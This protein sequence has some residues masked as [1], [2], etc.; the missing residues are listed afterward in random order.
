ML[1]ELIREAAGGE[2]VY[3]DDTTVKILEL[4]SAPA[5][6]EA[7]AES[8]AAGSDSKG[9]TRTGLFTSGV[10]ATRGGQRIALFFSGPQHAGENLQDVL[11]RRA[12]DLPPPIQM[13]DALSRNLPKDLHTIVANCLAH[14]RRQ[15][16]DVHERFPSECGYVLEA[17]EVVYRHDALARQRGLDERSARGLIVEGMA[18]AWLTRAFGDAQLVESLDLE[19]LL[20]QTVARHLADEIQALPEKP[21]G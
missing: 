13:C 19:G 18:S 7:L 12:T 6:A 8:G 5:R 21:H 1:Q 11:R 14:A 9:R 16:V 10:V 3:N 17:F 15:F 4:M 2:V 20:R